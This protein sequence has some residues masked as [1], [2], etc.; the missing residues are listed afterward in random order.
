V[1]KIHALTALLASI[2]DGRNGVSPAFEYKLDNGTIKIPT[3][4][5]YAQPH[6]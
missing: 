4:Y 1:H 2:L 6:L 3:I 5:L